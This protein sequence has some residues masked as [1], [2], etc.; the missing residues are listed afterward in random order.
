M[1]IQI[2]KTCLWAQARGGELKHKSQKMKGLCSQWKG[3]KTI[4][5]T[6]TRKT[7]ELWDSKEKKTHLW[8][9]KV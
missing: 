2:L 6:G 4:L 5:P 1:P 7:R 9:I 3:V 8:K